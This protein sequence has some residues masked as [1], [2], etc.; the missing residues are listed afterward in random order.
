MGVV[1]ELLGVLL[2]GLA[3]GGLDMA[4]DIDGWGGVFGRWEEGV[5]GMVGVVL[6]KAKDRLAVGDFPPLPAIRRGVVD[7]IATPDLGL[8]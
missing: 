2:R 5:V 1:R 8:L 6:M 3:R 7:F 4:G